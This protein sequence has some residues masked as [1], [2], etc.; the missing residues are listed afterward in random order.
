MNSLY[1]SADNQISY[2]MPA[3]VFSKLSKAL[4]A[5]KMDIDSV[6]YLE[7]AR[8]GYKM[9]GSCKVLPSGAHGVFLLPEKDTVVEF[10]CPDGDTW[11]AH[12][13]PV[14]NEIVVKNSPIARLR[15]PD[16]VTNWLLNGERGASSEAMCRHLFKAEAG[17]RQNGGKTDYP[18]DP[19]DFRR[20]R[21]FVEAT[22]CRNRIQEMASVSPIWAMYVSHWDELCEMMDAEVNWMR[23]D[24]S[25]S[26][27]NT[28][29]AM[30]AMQDI[31]LGHGEKQLCSQA[32]LLFSAREG[33]PSLVNTRHAIKIKA[34]VKYG[35]DV[36][37]RDNNG[38]T[39]LMIALRRF[40]G[41]T[42]PIKP[43]H[44]VIIKT[45]VECGADI[46]ARSPNTP[47]GVTA[48]EYAKN[49]LNAKWIA[50]AFSEAL[51]TPAAAVKT[52]PTRT[53]KR[54]I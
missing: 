2:G 26:A 5:A 30:H 36:N 4:A 6:I 13:D 52:Q 24:K 15:L 51:E 23:G 44:T 12:N 10:T 46:H 14:Q 16:P 53:P 17:Y 33:L 50:A 18:H 35:V 39:P 3:S 29:A 45:L 22:N 40:A 32:G 20:C 34:L 48:V 41:L 31:A 47:D 49:L 42:C 28:Y 11:Y 8:R 19:A 27:T 9:D 43:Y 21:L 7:D 38:N 1:V 25:G 37:T 54:K